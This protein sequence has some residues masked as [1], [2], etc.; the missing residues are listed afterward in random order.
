MHTGVLPALMSVHHTC[1]VYGAQE[2]ASDHLELELPK[3]MSYHVVLG[4]K[5]CSSTKAASVLNC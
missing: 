5:S 2:W 3:L 4:L 1:S